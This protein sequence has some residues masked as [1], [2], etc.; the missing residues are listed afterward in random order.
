[1]ASWVNGEL[2][3]LRGHRVRASAQAELPVLL[4]QGSLLESVDPARSE[5]VVATEDEGLALPA[6]AQPF[7]FRTVRLDITALAG[8]GAAR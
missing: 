4:E 6:D 5:V 3:A 8:L 1:M 2:G 7:L